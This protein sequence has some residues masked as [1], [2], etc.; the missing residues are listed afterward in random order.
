[1]PRPDKIAEVQAIAER[2]RAAQSIVLADYTGLSVEQMTAFRAQC[3]ASNVECRVVKNRLAMIAAQ[4][5]EL[6]EIKD[7]LRGPTALVFGPQSQVDPAKIVIDFAKEH[8]AMQVK[9]GVV[10]GQFLEPEQVV[11]LAKIPGWDELIAQ[12]M[13]SINSPLRGLAV[14]IGGVATALA[15]VIDAVAKQKAEAEAAA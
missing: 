4:D 15:R 11:A 12:M 5:A 8:E 7:H 3:R 2:L 6:L 13:G 1:M 10:D 14:T 9:G